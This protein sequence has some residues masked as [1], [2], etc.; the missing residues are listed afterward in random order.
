MLIGSL[1]V[2]AVDLFLRLVILK[3]KSPRLPVLHPKTG[4]HL[5]FVPAWIIAMLA[6]VL[7]IL[8]FIRG[9]G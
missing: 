5:F 2:V 9:R 7:G 6:G 3:E 1:I 4:G 8:L